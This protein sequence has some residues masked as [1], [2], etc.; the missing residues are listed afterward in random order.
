MQGPDTDAHDQPP[1]FIH[2]R[3]ATHGRS[4]QMGQSDLTAALS[5]PIMPDDQTSS[6]LS[7]CLKRS[8]P[9]VHCVSHITLR[10]RL[11]LLECLYRRRI[12]ACAR[13]TRFH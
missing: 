6:V 8:S 12:V 10:S 1:P 2:I 13:R 4:I 9:E 5:L 11:V 7:A 3:L